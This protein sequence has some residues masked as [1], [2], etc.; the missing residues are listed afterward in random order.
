MVC[1]YSASY[2][3]FRISKEYCPTLYLLLLG[4]YVKIDIHNILNSIGI[5]NGVIPIAVRKL[6]SI[7]EIVVSCIWLLLL[8][9][10]IQLINIEKTKTLH[11]LHVVLYLTFKIIKFKKIGRSSSLCFC[12]LANQLLLLILYAVI[13]H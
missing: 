3:K 8:D 9:S 5:F 12:L 13:S 7:V 4:T 6:E 1:Q 11:L 2:S 10:F